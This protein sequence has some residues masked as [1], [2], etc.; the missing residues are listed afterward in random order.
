M[1]DGN[2]HPWI[3]GIKIGC[4]NVFYGIRREQIVNEKQCSPYA[5]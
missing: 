5:V 2:I 3:G 1:I 4:N